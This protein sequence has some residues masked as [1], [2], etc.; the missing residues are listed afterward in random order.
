MTTLEIRDLHVSVGS[1]QILNGITLRITDVRVERL[2]GVSHQDC[3][4]EGCA[5][6]HDS[7]PRYPYSATPREHF[8]CEFQDQR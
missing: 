1:T 6:G 4:A 5:G 2:Q 3:V 8:L 7:I